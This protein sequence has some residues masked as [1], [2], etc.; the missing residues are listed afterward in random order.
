MA[1][2]TPANAQGADRWAVVV[3]TPTGTPRGFYGPKTI[4]GAIFWDRVANAGSVESLQQA[5]ILA[6]RWSTDGQ[7]NCLKGSLTLGTLAPPF[8]G[9]RD[10]VQIYTLGYLP[11]ES[12]TTYYARYAGRAVSP[13]SSRVQDGDWRTLE[14]EG[15]YRDIESLEAPNTPYERD[16]DVGTVARGLLRAVGRGWA[17]LPDSPTSP[18]LPDVGANLA[19]KVYPAYAPMDEFLEDLAAA[20]AAAGVEVAYG[21]DADRAPFFRPRDTGSQ[22]L[23]LRTPGVTAEPPQIQGDLENI[24]TAVR[25][26]LGSGNL[27]RYR[28][29]WLQPASEHMLA[30][31]RDPI[32]Y[33]SSSGQMVYDAPRSVQKETPEGVPGLI[34]PDDLTLTIT[35]GTVVASYDGEGNQD[36]T[37]TPGRIID[38]VGSS[39]AVVRAVTPGHISMQLSASSLVG[40]KM[41]EIAGVELVCAPA[42]DKDSGEPTWQAPQNATVYAHLRFLTGVELPLTVVPLRVYHKKNAEA[43]RV[44][45]TWGDLARATGDVFMLT[46][47]W[48]IRLNIGCHASP[49]KPME[50]A[51]ASFRFFRINKAGLDAAAKKEYRLPQE[52]ALAVS[53]QG[54]YR[55][56][57]TVGVTYPDGSGASGLEALSWEYLVDKNGIRTQVKTGQRLGYG[58]PE[59]ARMEIQQAQAIHRIRRLGLRARRPEPLALAAYTSGVG[60]GGDAPTDDPASPGGFNANFNGVDAIFSW[61]PVPDV[62]SYEVEVWTDGSLRRTETVQ[63]PA[64]VYTLTKN[65]ADNTTPKAA[66]EVRVR[67]MRGGAKSGQGFYSV[68]NPAPVAPGSIALVGEVLGLV[69]SVGSPAEPDVDHLEIQADDNPS[70]SSP[71]NYRVYGWS[72]QKIS[73]ESLTG[74]TYVRSRWVDVFGQAGA[75]SST[76]N[77]SGQ[78]VGSDYIASQAIDVAKFA[79]GLRPVQIVSSLPTLPNSNYPEGAVVFL[80]TDDKLYRSTGTSWTASVPAADL[81][82]QITTTQISDNAIS[83]PKLAAGAV[84]ANELAANSVIAG[85]IAAGAVGANEIAARAITAQKLAIGDYSNLVINDAS[86]SGNLEDWLFVTLAPGISG[87]ESPWVIVQ[88][89]RDSYFQNPGV[90]PWGFPVEPGKG[91]FVRCRA[92]TPTSNPS[93]YPFGPGLLFRDVNGNIIGWFR[94]AQISASSSWQNVGGIVIAPSNAAFGSFWAQ[95][96]KPWGTELDKPWYYSHPVIRR[97]NDGELTVDGSITANKLTALQLSALVGTFGGG[98]G[99]V[100]I[101]SRGVRLYEG[102]NNPSVAFGDLSGLQWGNTIFPAGTRGFWAKGGGLYLTDYPRVLLASSF[103]SES[104]YF[105]GSVPGGGTGTYTSTSVRAYL[106]TPITKISGRKV[107]VIPIRISYQYLVFTVNRQVVSA[108]FSDGS[109]NWWS[110]SGVPTGTTINS[111]RLVVT[112]DYKNNSFTSYDPGSAFYDY[113][114]LVVFEVPD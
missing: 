80:T 3:R 16:T 68:S 96:D 2:L 9:A 71:R 55:P 91:Y 113:W 54:E 93:S 88:A 26:K 62:D 95:I 66:V 45:L 32:T 13:P 85:K 79:S 20:A 59:T 58:D 29:T 104:I 82:G 44:L 69:Y 77:S 92:H 43:V 110:W 107:V 8:V 70:F 103:I 94:A 7:G 86:A 31:G 109:S 39:F 72:G 100:G 36:P 4:A 47:S 67:S 76:A 108:E 98:A 23:D 14:L 60:G 105:T 78:L 17:T 106:R 34:P 81:A 99:E 5:P 27:T 42:V 101:D 12:P 6:V 15:L 21:V 22:P 84:T 64:Y 11:G 56:L 52:N 112:I 87:S 57:P 28:P 10:I 30:D 46:S 19:G 18:W 73:L 25:W 1:D 90:A 114:H 35:D 49:A 102:I 111:I 63:Q 41:S 74:P 38:G 83:T 24:V 75:W 48:Q 33:V 97:A 53:L 89:N 40:L 61:N 37:P 65:R 51:I 50:W